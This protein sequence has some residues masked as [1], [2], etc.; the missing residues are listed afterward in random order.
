MKKSLII[1]VMVD[2]VQLIDLESIQD[3]LYEIFDEYE[4]KRITMQLQD[5]PVVRPR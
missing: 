1:T 2:D 5:E 4:N 3:K